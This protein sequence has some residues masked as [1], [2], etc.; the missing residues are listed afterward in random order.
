[1][2]TLNGVL[3]ALAVGVATLSIGCTKEGPAEKAG[4]AIDK[5]AEQ[6]A[7]KAKEVTNSIVGKEGVAETTGKKLDNAI[8]KTGDK[9]QE[10]GNAAKEKTSN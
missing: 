10:I 7:D 1:M 8:E 2:R 4:E 9:M 5:A 6:T 3:V